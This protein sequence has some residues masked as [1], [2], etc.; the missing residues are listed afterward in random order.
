MSSVSLINGHIDEEVRSDKIMTNFEHIKNMDIESFA[1]FIAMDR[2]RTIEELAK[3]LKFTVTFP[4]NYLYNDFSALVKYLE[5]E[6][7]AE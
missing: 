2:K 5:S 3:A 7:D 6:R 1:M 4:E